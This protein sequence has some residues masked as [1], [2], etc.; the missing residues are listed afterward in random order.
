MVRSGINPAQA[1]PGAVYNAVDGV[2][3]FVTAGAF[4]RVLAAR[5]AGH[6]SIAVSHCPA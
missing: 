5:N 2:V 3:M 4:T 1:M 6:P